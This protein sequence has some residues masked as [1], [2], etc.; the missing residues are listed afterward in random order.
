MT[1][2]RVGHG[3]PTR[4]GR[5]RR[6]RDHHDSDDPGVLADSPAPGSL[7][8]CQSECQWPGRPPRGTGT[9]KVSDS[10][11]GVIQ[12]SG[13]LFVGRAVTSHRSQVVTIYATAAGDP[14]S[15]PALGKHGHVTTRSSS[16]GRPSHHHG[17]VTSR[18][19]GSRPPRPLPDA[20]RDLRYQDRR[21]RL[22]QMDEG[23][24]DFTFCPRSFGKAVMVCRT[25]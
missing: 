18:V 19:S 8:G 20:N 21:S 3:T 25:E 7:A 9:G 2:S 12:Y 1:W 22:A 14:G 13:I 15:N 17:R 23:G 16:P 6:R 5:R 24:W 4:P 10:A 11:V